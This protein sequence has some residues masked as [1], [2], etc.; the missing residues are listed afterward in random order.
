TLDAMPGKQMAI[1]ADLSSGL[2]DEEQ[3]KARRAKIQRE[4]DFFGAMDGA[5][6]FVKGDATISIVVAFVNIIGGLVI[7]MVAD[8]KSF[9]EAWQLYTLLTV[10]DGLVSQLP[11]LLISTATGMLVTRSASESDVNTDFIKQFVSQPRVLVVAG[12]VL[13]AISVVPGFPKIQFWA[14]AATLI[15]LGYNL[16]KEE[17]RVPSMAELKAAVEPPVSETEYFKNIDNVYTLLSVEQ[18]EMEFGYSLIPLVDESSGGVFLDR[19]VMFRKQFALDMGMVVPSVRLRDNGALNPNQYTIKLKGEEVARGEVLVNHYLALDSGS[20]TD[21]I[22]GINT[23]EPAFGIP[24]LWISAN[25]RDEAEV[26]GYTII[27][28]VSVIITHLSEVIKS[29]AHEL[30]SRQDVSTILENVKKTSK[31]IVEDTVPSIISIGDLQKVL[32]NLLRENIP[33]KDMETILE[34]ISDYGASIKDTDMLTEYVRQ[35]LKRTI[36]RKFSEAGSLKVITL[37]ANIENIIMAGVKKSDH[38]TYLAI[39]PDVVQKIVNA[40]IEQINK[41][42][43]IVSVPIVLASPIVRIY[44]KKMVDQFCP[45]TL[46][47]SFNEI[48]T[49]VQIQSLGNIEIQ[50]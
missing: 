1:D 30:L 16:I 22:S 24:A 46:V 2:I 48:D 4:A 43:N 14:L 44:F 21:E 7:G 19:V 15:F 49:T 12:I 29:H 28:P 6:K 11:S 39:E 5:T 17:N 9:Q 8:H 34:T 33:I 32:C 35:A 3:A 20:V 45:G 31:A 18:I 37:D 10:G 25:K 26:A 42:K 50:Q 41:V 38:G 47:L 36:T 27:D 40:L 13:V 23:V